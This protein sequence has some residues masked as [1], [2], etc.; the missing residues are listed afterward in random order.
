MQARVNDSSSQV[1][2]IFA[3]ITRD[4]IAPVTAPL[5]AYLKARSHQ[6]YI[7]TELAERLAEADVEVD[8][9]RVFDRGG[10]AKRSTI[11]ITF[12]GDG[13][14]LA[15]SQ[16]SLQY[17]VPI[18]GVNLG[19][20]GFLSDIRPDD[21]IHAVERIIDEQYRVQKRM[22]LCGKIAEGGE[23]FYALNDIVV[24]KSGNT[25]VIEIDTYLNDEYVATFFA[26]GI[27]LSTPTGS[28]AYSL[29]TGGPVVIPSVEA[30]IVSPIS[31][32]ALTARPLIVPC[33]DTVR[34]V[35][36]PSDGI[37]MVMTDGKVEA[38]ELSELEL[39]VRKGQ[40]Y[41]KLVKGIGPSYFDTLREKLH[42]ATD[43]RRNSI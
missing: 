39:T 8:Q 11:L 13:T 22:T 6:Y 1:F 10:V 40:K 43:A 32:H 23:E 12:G 14:M 37:A 19:K 35:T 7:E 41:V 29:A 20:L 42:W 34:L 33:G 21:V 16:F 15:V 3:N 30:I 27:I 38:S 31:A 25:K 28:T 24:S 18:L 2:G 17:D 5:I 4:D 26:D 36:K 9:S